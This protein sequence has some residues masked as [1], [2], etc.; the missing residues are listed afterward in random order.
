MT[1]RI[2]RMPD[3]QLTSNPVHSVAANQGWPEVDCALVEDGR[4]AVPLFPLELLP[5]PWRSWVSE[6]ARSAGAPVD[7]VAQAL[8]AVVA[9]LCGAGALVRVTPGWSEPL[10]LWQALVGR[11]SSGKSPALAALRALLGS[12]E[13][14][15]R[16]GE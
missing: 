6:T 8:L 7:Y 3:S 2:A 13:D 9:G 12:L 4:R 5:L 1:R 14:E 11:P 15:L 10:V 16:V